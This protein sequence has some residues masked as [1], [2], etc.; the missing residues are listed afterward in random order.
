MK[1]HLLSV[2]LLAAALSAAQPPRYDA[3][4][5]GSTQLDKSAQDRIKV[6]TDYWRL[7]FDIRNGGMLDTIV[8]PHG[9]GSNLLLTPASLA[10][11][12]W[13]AARSPR[14]DVR[15]SQ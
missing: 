5:G 7:E 12:G 11:D 15:S 3:P 9:S 8:F 6:S 4:G 10:V 2:P 13:T 14:V 1:I